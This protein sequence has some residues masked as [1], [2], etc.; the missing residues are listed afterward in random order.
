MPA[1]KWPPPVKLH[2]A[3]NRDYVLYKNVQHYL[4]PAGSAESRRNYAALLQ[5]LAGAD[6]NVTAAPEP[7]GLAVAEVF[8]RWL[9]EEAPKLANAHEADCVGYAFGPALRLFARTPAADFDAGLLEEARDDMVVR[10]GWAPCTVRHACSRVR[11]VWRWAERKRLVPRGSW[12]NLR[13]LP[14]LPPHDARFRSRP[15]PRKAFSREEVEKA[16]AFC[17]PPLAAALTF[18]F[19]TGCRSQDARRLKPGQIDR[20]GDVWGYRP[21][22]HKGTWRGAG[23][24]VMIGPRCQEALVPWLEGKGPDEWAFPCHA[25]V[26]RSSRKTDWLRGEHCYS[27]QAYGRGAAAAGKRAGLGGFQSYC[28]RHSAKQRVAREMGLD[29]ARSFLGQESLSVTD[30]YARARDSEMARE[31]ARTLG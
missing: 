14:P 5:R 2:K 30:N 24:E 21:P 4:G 15:E 8:A 6:P 1:P 23:R 7:A 11:R 20:S 31:V 16:L 22:Q 27:R 3:S 10:E 17:V 9:A 13:T 12:A 26:P 28:L 29:F 18:Q 25:R 19:W